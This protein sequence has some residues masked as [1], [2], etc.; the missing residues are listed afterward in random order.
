MYTH[1]EHVMLCTHTH[2]ACDAVYTHT[3]PWHVMLCIHTHTQSMC[4]PRSG[5]FC[6]Y[7]TLHNIGFYRLHL[8]LHYKNILRKTR[9]FNPWVDPGISCLAGLHHLTQNDKCLG[10]EDKKEDNPASLLERIKTVGV[11][12][13]IR[14][15]SGKIGPRTYWTHQI[16]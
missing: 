10:P 16:K 1:T 14:I 6:S 4:L 11:H 9:D 12:G 8:A 5:L 3:Q 7:S 15:K 13:H 2:T